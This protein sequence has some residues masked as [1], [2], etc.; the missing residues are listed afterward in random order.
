[1]LA[2]G[3]L[4]YVAGDVDKPLALVGELCP[5][6]EPDKELDWR[7]AWLAGSPLIEMGLNR[8]QDGALG[9]DL[10]ERV[11]HRLANLVGGGRLNPMERAD[12]GRILAY[13]GDPRPGVGVDPETGL[14]DIVWCEIPAGAFLM[15]SDRN[16]DRRALDDELP[17]HELTLSAF[18]MS[19]YLV[20]NAQFA[21]FIG[22]GAYLERRY[23][24]EAE[25]AGVWQDGCV[26]G[27]RDKEP[28]NRPVDFGAPFNLPNHPVVGVTWHEALAFCYWLSEQGQGQTLPLQVWRKGRVETLDL[29]PGAFKVRLPSEAQW[30]KAARG[31]DGHIYSWGDKPDPDRANCRDTGI[32]CTCAVGCFP[33]GASPYGVLDMSGNIRE[34]CQTKWRSSYKEPA[35]ESLEGTDPRVVRGV[36]WSYGQIEARCAYRYKS[37]PNL[38]DNSWGFRVVVSLGSP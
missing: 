24:T 12:A 20:T 34:W 38:R 8:V 16:K 30:E 31:T 17:Q 11:R 19:R 29:E 32:G 13:L 1:L 7:K 18:Y 4:V 21:A 36:P 27:W 23:W 14:P 6:Q 5:K 3:R 25:T 37:N 26:K 28:R 35:D 2:V 10:L 22:D 15:G 9:R 33:A